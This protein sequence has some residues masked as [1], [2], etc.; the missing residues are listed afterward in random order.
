MKGN[1]K[2]F[3]PTQ[4]LSLVSLAK[5]TGSLAVERKEANASLD[6]KEGKLIYATIGDADGSLVSVLAR[7]GRLSKEQAES[8]KKASAKTSDKQLGLLLIQKGYVTQADIVKSIKRHA[9][10]SV[11]HFAGWADGNFE[12]DQEASPDDGRIIVPID[13]ESVI[14]QIARMQKRDSDLKAE[15]PSLDVSLKFSNRPDVKLQDLQ[16]T[17]DE[18]RVL[19]FIK[20]ENSVSMIANKLN[21]TDMQIRRVVGSLREAGL[22]ELAHARRKVEMS[23]EEKMEKQLVVKRLIKRIQSI[24]A[25]S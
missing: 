6:F 8:L 18:W 9:L 20:P 3:S 19:N 17:K 21:M 23:D 5:K 11:T 12:F 1:L 22:V 13:L 24:G 14:I 25:E 7:S 2:D 16:L 15:I 4:L 10:A